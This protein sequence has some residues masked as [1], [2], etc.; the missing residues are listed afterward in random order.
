MPDA[1]ASGGPSLYGGTFGA[2]LD[3][4]ASAVTTRGTGHVIDVGVPRTGAPRA[5]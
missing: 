5:S 1:S 2:P 4:E 3:E